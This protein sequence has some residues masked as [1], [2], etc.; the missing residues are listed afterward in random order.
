M[1]YATTH[2][3]T[4]H[5]LDFAAVCL[6]GLKYSLVARGLQGSRALRAT[7]AQTS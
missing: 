6:V 5:R 7:V 4:F 3:S 2:M 1:S